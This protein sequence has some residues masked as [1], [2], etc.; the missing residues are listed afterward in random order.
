[1]K[2]IVL[3]CVCALLAGCAAAPTFE[4]LG[5]VQHEQPAV[6]KTASADI[7]ADALE[8]ENGTDGAWLCGSY[9][10]E[11]RTRQAESLAET[12]Q[13]LS[14]CEEDNLTVMTLSD[15]GMKRYEWVWT[16]M[17][18]EG[19]Q[20]GRAVVLDDGAFHYCLSAVGP[21]EQ[22][23]SLAAEWNTLFSTFRAE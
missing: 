14:G 18:E 22:G 2:I 6:R 1:M 15:H 11:I 4:T 9:Y 23:S 5:P 21:A 16:A 12:V 3:L 17:S 7:P 8:L 10:L 19:R 20:L 13:V